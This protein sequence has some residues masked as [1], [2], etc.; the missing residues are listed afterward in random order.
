MKLPIHYSRIPAYSLIEVLIAS[1]ILLTGIAAVAMMAHTMF[2]QEESNGRITRALNLQEQ[3]ATLWQLGLSSDTITNIL[4]E[5][6]LSTNPP[7]ADA[8]SLSFTTNA[9]ITNLGTGIVES[10]N[11]SV[12]FHSATAANGTLVYQT[13]VVTVVRPSTR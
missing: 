7:G 10:A 9:N 2:L 11:L 8:V 1:G 5:R 12:V 6:C 3:A 13:N 4:P